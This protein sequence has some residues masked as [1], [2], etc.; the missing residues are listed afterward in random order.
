M[1][2]EEK[3]FGIQMNAI[4]SMCLAHVM[5]AIDRKVDSDELEKLNNFISE[6]NELANETDKIIEDLLDKDIYQIYSEFTTKPKS[7]MSRKE[8]DELNNQAN[9][10]AHICLMSMSA[11]LLLAKDLKEVQALNKLIANIMSKATKASHIIDVNIDMSLEE[12]SNKLGI[13]SHAWYKEFVNKNV[14]DVHNATTKKKLD[15]LMS[16]LRLRRYGAE[17]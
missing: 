9:T 16:H 14:S 13:D 1:K 17:Y 5:D 6:L 7:K 15:D 3:L 11:L 12:I 10:V 4:L 2:D 8:K